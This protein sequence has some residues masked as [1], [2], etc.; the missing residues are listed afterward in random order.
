MSALPCFRQLTL[1]FRL[2]RYPRACCDQW[3]ETVVTNP[4]NNPNPLIMRDAP[5][6]CAGRN[7]AAEYLLAEKPH[8]IGAVLTIQRS[9]LGGQNRVVDQLSGGIGARRRQH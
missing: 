6:S 5:S 9:Y 1:N 8:I 7:F 4:L 3:P 2:T